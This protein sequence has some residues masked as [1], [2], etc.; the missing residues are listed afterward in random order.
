MLG[1]QNKRGIAA[2]SFRPQDH[3]HIELFNIRLACYLEDI[4]DAASQF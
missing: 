2:L 4:W 3:Q 1:E